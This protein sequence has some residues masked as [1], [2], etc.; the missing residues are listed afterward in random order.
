M[1]KIIVAAGLM[2]VVTFPFGAAA[3]QTAVL[4]IEGEHYQ[5]VIGSIGEPIAVD[6]KTGVELHVTMLGHE[7]MAAND[8][9]AEGGGVTGLEQTLQVE[10]IA[11]DARKVLDLTPTYNTPGSYN[12]PFYPTEAI[13]LSYRLFG[14]INNTPVD[15]VF[16]CRQ[17]GAASAEEGEKEIS[18]GVRQISKVGG[19]GCPADKAEL[20][21]P[22]PSA[23]VAAVDDTARSANAW[24]LVGTGLG[25]LALG[26]ALLRRRG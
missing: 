20:G 21:F 11:G 18:Q 7:E 6:D 26:A 12:A 1:Q 8:H 3:H 19:F 10:L 13:E 23:A 4:E 9:H 17:E 14:T 22:A 16:A 15:L 25:A 5:V 24:G 2:M